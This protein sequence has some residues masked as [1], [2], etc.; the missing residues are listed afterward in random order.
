MR[1]PVPLL[2]VVGVVVGVVTSVAS[3]AA[4]ALIIAAA[5]IG[6]VVPE[7]SR[8][9][10][11]LVALVA[12][13]VVF[14]AR[15][16][17]AALES[18]L[19]TSLGPLLD[20]RFAPP[21]WLEGRVVDDG[22]MSGDAALVSID[23]ARARVGSEWRPVS[24]RATISIGGQSASQA[25]ASW[26]RG[27]RL[28]APVLVRRPQIWLNF[29]GPSER[30]QRLRRTADI[31]GTV[32]S[33]SLVEVHAGSRASETGAA[34]R[35]FV[36][37]EIRRS[38]G[39]ISGES[40]A[41]IVAI[42]IG[43]RTSLDPATVRQLQRAG[44]YHVIAIS[45]GNIA[46]VVVAS[47][48][49]LRLL[50]RSRRVV[51]ILTT[52]FVLGY[53]AV[54]GDQAS[55]ERAVAAA[56]VVLALQGAGWAAPAWR[57]F[58][59]ALLLVVAIDPMTVI[60]AGAWLSFGATLG[61]LLLARPVAEWLRRGRTLGRTA[62]AM[63][64]LFAATV[65]AELALLPVGAAVFAQVSLAG[66]LLNFVAIPAMALVQMAGLAIVAL[67]SFS[68]SAANVAAHVAH[69]G[70]SAIVGSA[71]VLDFLPWLSWQT[72]PV[73][74]A[75]TIAYYAAAALAI[76]GRIRIY[77]V[78]FAGVAAL[79]L[80]VIVLSPVWPARGGP[81][82]GWLR[83]T[84]LDVGQGDAILV[85]FP[86]GQS[87]LVDAGG[88]ATGFDIGSRVV[89]PALWARGARQL[90]WLAVTHGD[91]DHAGGA[92]SLVNDLGP[93]EV[94][95]GVPV[96]RNAVMQQL[97]AA[98]QTGGAAWAR[99]VAGQSLEV[100]SAVVE[101]L[102]PPI[103]D[104]E[105]PITRNDDSIVLRLSFGDVAVML[106]GDIGVAAEREL[107]LESRPRLRLLKA[108]H[109]GSRTSS[110]PALVGGWLPQAVIVSVGRGNSFGHPAPDV[111]ARYAQYGVDVFRTDRDGAIA[112]ETDGREVRLSTA[113]GRKWLLTA[114]GR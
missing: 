94:W 92:L 75:W 76:L 47:L 36:R 10:V 90:D 26:T 29:G 61:I 34:I 1:A 41:V 33:A 7:P 71:N 24:G 59:I 87:L 30:W 65:A 83:V 91:I 23:V 55:V 86:A 46:I 97:R 101:V 85:Q 21:V 64:I 100:G 16:R 99:L 80:L 60:D 109:H 20:D 70:V 14:G 107:W 84:F 42:L 52:V 113:T 15:A 8:R 22:A 2:L 69:V 106:T 96:G 45:G 38:V 72:P 81:P 13:G 105:R 12:A 49:L 40:A 27:R 89:R 73:S 19:V 58:L 93:R 95:E 103:P 44:T 79:S 48:F 67:C 102:N 74:I 4:A 37:R 25:V 108:P 50:F 82:N 110:S 98:A 43:D 3:L 9:W 18:T 32:K 112:V 54:V 6:L 63:L 66:L 11:I 5:S 62:N 17:D 35:R 28:A 78:T 57:I 53:G 56:V 31:T 111:L 114:V 51:A 104:W 39:P 68:S 77:R 88:S